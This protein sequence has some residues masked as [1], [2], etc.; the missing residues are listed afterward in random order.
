M[1]DART[2]FC[3]MALIEKA[4]A[5][6]GGEL[7]TGLSDEAA[8]FIVSVIVQDLNLQTDFPEISNH[9]PNFFDECDPT[10]LEIDN[11]NFSALIERL[12]GLKP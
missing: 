5:S 6:G 11:L 9:P 4:Q 1:H 10:T 8:N 3:G 2:Y 7:G 12:F